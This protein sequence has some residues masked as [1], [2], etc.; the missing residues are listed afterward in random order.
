MFE[1]TQGVL[2]RMCGLVS[3]EKDAIDGSIIRRET[4]GISC[5]SEKH[6]YMALWLVTKID[7]QVMLLHEY[8]LILTSIMM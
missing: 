5:L 3:G 4:T 7:Y 6:I 2:L 1:Q 8:D